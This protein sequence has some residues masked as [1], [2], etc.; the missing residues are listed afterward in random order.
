MVLYRINFIKIIKE[1]YINVSDGV[2]KT[3]N[4]MVVLVERLN[5][6]NNQVSGNKS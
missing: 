4:Y 3:Y 1:C 2:D 5:I 6:L